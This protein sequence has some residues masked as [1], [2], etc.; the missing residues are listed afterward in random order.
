MN[1][2]KKQLKKVRNPNHQPD[3]MDGSISAWLSELAE[4]A[5]NR[6]EELEKSTKLQINVLEKAVMWA[7]TAEICLE[8][9]EIHNKSLR[10]ALQ[11]VID[12]EPGSIAIASIL[13]EGLDRIDIKHNERP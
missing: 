13:L 3:F 2:I 8:K 10:L 6:I 11:G 9:A 5:L 4:N 7:E 12:Q 1:D